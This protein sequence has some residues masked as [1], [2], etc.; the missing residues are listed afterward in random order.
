MV[1][2]GT[3]AAEG[4]GTGGTGDGLVPVDYAGA[5]PL[6]EVL[7]VRF[8]VTEQAGGEA[9]A[10]GVALIDGGIE[11]VVADE[12]QQRAEV[13]F[14]RQC[15][16]SGHIYD[17]G[18]DEAGARFQ[19]L[20]A[21]QTLAT[22]P[23]Q[24]GLCGHH[25][26]RR[27]LAYHGAHK[28][29]FGGVIEADPDLADHLHQAFHQ[30]IP[31]SATLHEQAAGA[32]AALAGGD[33]GGL[34]YRVH[35]AIDVAHI[36]HDQRVVATHFEGQDLAGLTGK[37]LVQEVPGA[38][39]SGEKEAIDVRIAGQRLAGLDLALHQVEY[40]LGQPRLLPDLQHGLGHHG[41][42]L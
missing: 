5:D 12:L 35:R 23:L 34:H 17:A 32:G 24:V 22:Q 37:L 20:E 13:L 19:M 26:Q 15:G 6:E 3:Y 4:R 31:L 29:L 38:G 27:L 25:A 36:F 41:G 30:G 8:A 18:G 14:I 10:G 33:K 7:P 28:G 1:A 40:A 11:V 16:N 9:E 42:Q 21:E 39:R 2:G